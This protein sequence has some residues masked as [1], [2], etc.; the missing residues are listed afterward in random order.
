MGRCHRGGSGSGAAE[1]CLKRGCCSAEGFSEKS[2]ALGAPK[3]G[4]NIACL[5]SRISRPRPASGSSDWD[6]LVLVGSKASTPAEK[7][8]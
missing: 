8:A 1:S 5:M 2:G 4:R 6:A 7:A 3:E